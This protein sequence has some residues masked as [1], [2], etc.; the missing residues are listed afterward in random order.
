MTKWLIAVAFAVL[1]GVAHAGEAGDI[2]VERLEA[3][4]HDDGATGLAP[5]VETGDGEA[6]FAEG[7]LSFVGGIERYVQAMYRHGLSA[8]QDDFLFELMELSPSGNETP[9]APRDVEPLSYAAYREILQ[10]LVTALDRARDSFLAAGEAGGF[11]VLL[12]VF[13][14]RIDGD[15]DG[16]AT[17]AETLRNLIFAGANSISDTMGESGPDE[18][19]MPATMEIGFD[20]ADAFWLAGYSQVLA[21]Q[22]D[23]ALAHDFSELASVFFHR[24]FP[25]AG[26][27]MQPYARGD[28]GMMG[29][30]ADAFIADLIAAVHSLDFPVQDP[31]RLAGVRERLLSITQFS[32]SN[33]D[34]IMAETDDNRELVP[35]PDQTSIFGDQQVTRKMIAA[36]QIG[37]DTTD[38]V[39]NGELLLPH[40]RFSQGFDL[41]AYFETAERTDL[42]LILTGAGAVPFL[43]DGTIVTAEDFGPLLSV[44]GDD[45][46]GYMA[47]FN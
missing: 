43:A 35:S 40:W 20:A 28:A 41:K 2:L 42:V 27:P 38:K 3:G 45:L 31:E 8:P 9:A 36:W 33:W 37:L 39:L 18:E 15:G 29:P 21:A 16:E 23:F 24:L 1:G 4:L 26:F 14:I 25:L 12:D 19:D 13:N 7:F 46:F 10:D 30:E 34:A 6:L 47:W 5:F 17:D 32:R 11:V 22:S 44:F